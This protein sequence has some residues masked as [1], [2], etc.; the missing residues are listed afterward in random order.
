M[1]A[2]PRGPM[3]EVSPSP[4]PP[5]VAP[6]PPP[7]EVW[8]RFLEEP[9]SPDPPPIL[10]EPAP[11]RTLEPGTILGDWEI[12]RFLARGG[13]GEV[14]A[15]FYRP[16]H[17]RYA[18]KVLGGDH[19]DDPDALTRFHYEYWAL[20]R[21]KHEAIVAPFCAGK[22]DGLRWYAMELLEGESLDRVVER[23]LLS[24]LRACRIGVRIADALTVVHATNIVHRDLKPGNIF[25]L[26][27]T[28]DRVK[29]LDLGIAK[30][31]PEFFADAEMRPRVEERL[32]TLPG[33][34]IG[35]AGY[36]APE[37][38][39]GAKAA[40]AQDIYG[41]AATLFR[42]TA[43]RS[44]YATL[45]APDPGDEPRWSEALGRP[46]PRAFEL[47]LRKA[48]AV[49]PSCRQP[50][51]SEFR[52]QLQLVV[53][54]LEAE[55][56]E[57][58]DAD[59]RAPPRGGDAPTVLDTA[60]PILGDAGQ[61]PEESGADPASIADAGPRPE[62]NAIAIEPVARLGVVDDLPAPLASRPPPDPGDGDGPGDDERRA[63][64]SAAPTASKIVSPGPRRRWAPLAVGAL[65][66]I[67]AGFALGRLSADADDALARWTRAAAAARSA[68][69]EPPPVSTPVLVA[70]APSPEP[71]PE[72]RAPAELLSD[73]APAK[74]AG[75]TRPRRLSRAAFRDVVASEAAALAP[76]V[77]V[78]P[79]GTE[80]AAEVR[81]RPDGAVE[82]VRLVPDLSFIALRCARKALGGLRFPQADAPSTHTWP[83]R[84]P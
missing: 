41:L 71:V 58:D 59:R 84:R 6:P 3:S 8:R 26:K 22:D 76:C 34:P 54:E 36:M 46:L 81:V 31:L 78:L 1:G 25:L 49:D 55:A 68:A 5:A 39:L 74:T 57:E 29:L 17:R 69:I 19:H 65:V 9:L 15:A 2:S 30:L 60:S 75:S 44:P 20:T 70:P 51:M 67:A 11:R 33:A 61:R 37:V 79:E 12:L 28:E 16:A 73:P 7:A 10:V 27:G 21:V 14:F 63:R 50:S 4:S 42:L 72:V 82:S 40:P 24:P 38:I 56:A 18:L 23:E 45:L 53:E 64:A 77:E 48:L 43:G 13:M 62:R 35:T 47:V 83:L 52:D 66:C 32:Q 80:V